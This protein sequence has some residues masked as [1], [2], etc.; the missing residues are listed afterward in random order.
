MME[1][2]LKQQ[3]LDE[4]GLFT[5]ASVHLTVDGSND[6]QMTMRHLAS[7]DDDGS[8]YHESV[9]SILSLA[10]ALKA[11]AVTVGSCAFDLHWL[12]GASWSFMAITPLECDKWVAALNTSLKGAGSSRGTAPYDE[13][14]DPSVPSAPVSIPLPLPPPSPAIAVHTPATAEVEAEVETLRVRVSQLSAALSAEGAA[15]DAAAREAT[16]LRADLA[17]ASQVRCNPLHV[18]PS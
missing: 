4:D 8:I 5:W 11:K 12:S 13:A 6:G 16:R 2:E 15:A 14:I 1:G 18:A 7:D 3:C 10:G 9:P 17:A